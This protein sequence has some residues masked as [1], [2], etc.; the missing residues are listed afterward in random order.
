MTMAGKYFAEIAFRRDGSSRFHPDHRW[1]NFGSVGLAWL[2]SRE[3]FLREIN[4]LNYL[5]LRFSYG[6]VGNDASLDYC[7][8]DVFV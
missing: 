7:G 3:N 2:I 1:G 6:E 5:K 8:L 4:W